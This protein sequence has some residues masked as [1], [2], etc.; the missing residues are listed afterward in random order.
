MAGRPPKPYLVLATEKKSHRTKAEMKQRDRGEKALLGGSNLK[1]RPEVK[2]NVQ[3]HKEFLRLSKLLNTLEKN[4]SIY[5]PVINRY[6][7][8]Q[9]E[10]NDLEEQKVYFYS[11]VKELKES[12]EN[13]VNKIEDRESAALML[14]DHSR[15]MA[16]MQNGIIKLDA[17]LQ[18]K[19]RMLLDIERE[20]I[21]TIASALRN[22]PRKVEKKENALAQ[23]L[24]N[25]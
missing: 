11:L 15:Q 8:I 4:D 3:A 18:T 23:A 10:C 16:V 12:F 1:E 17:N 22:V 13:V 25:D 9:A 21:M 6:C 7:L 14:M 2:N 19:R 5:E 20:S 24:A